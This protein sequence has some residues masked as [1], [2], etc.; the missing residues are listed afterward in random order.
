MRRRSRDTGW[1]FTLVAGG[2]AL[3]VCAVMIATRLLVPSERA[4]IPTEAWPW[5]SEGVGVDPLGPGDPFR[6][7]DVVV[8]MD[9]RSIEAWAEDAARLPWTVTGRPPLGDEVTFDVLRAGTLIRFV[10]PREPFPLER[11]GGASIGLAVFGGG[12]LLLA[13]FLLLRRP[14]SP[15]LRIL[16]TATAANAASILA[17]EIDLQPTDL[18]FESPFLV[19]FGLGAVGSLVF[20]SCVVHVLAIYPVRSG[21]V[22]R[23]P[24]LIPALYAAPIAAF[25]IGLPVARF[26]GGNI[27]DSI[28]RTA[29]VVGAIGTVMLGLIVAA[30]LAGYRR[31]P[32]PRRRQ[33][34]AI[35][36]SLVLA[37]G[38]ELILIAV[39][40]ALNGRPIVPRNTAA[41]LALPVPI[42][43][44]VAVVRDRLFQVDLLVGSRERIVAA[45]EEERRRIRR[46]LHDG[47][48]PMLAAIGLKV[49]LARSR[50]RVDPDEAETVLDET[51]AA[52]GSVVADIRRIARDLRPPSLDALGLVGAIRQQADALA[53]RH[54]RSPEIMIAAEDPLPVLPAATEVAAYRIIVEA[55]MNVIRHADATRCQIRI[56][57]DREALTIEVVDDG[58]GM[59]DGAIGVGTRSIHERAGEVGGEATIERLPSGGTRVASQLPFRPAAR[60]ARALDE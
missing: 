7:G 36:A 11:I 47:L 42:A 43:L 33:V 37:A 8:A 55:M 57:V 32:E 27:L 60:E 46:E 38:A 54:G 39:P 10:A 41:V 23:R 53:D 18:A 48:G 16:F 45:R 31:T 29:S 5:T 44:I 26:A 59:P 58:R 25:V 4:V 13:L 40:I 34:R 51:R 56:A 6:A 9:G 28:D 21:V 19:A 24:W 17:W 49:D 14:W 3:I 50:L 20:W 35:G 30:T 52:I 12:A 15:A 22:V 1:I 2:G